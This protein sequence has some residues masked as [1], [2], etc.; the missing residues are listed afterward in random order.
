M[1]YPDEATARQLAAARPDRST[2]LAANAGSGKTKVLTDRV[3]RLLL[4]GTPPQHILCLT[5]TKA[6]ASEMQN[7][8]F[9]RLGEWAML[10]EDD[11]RH[12]VAKLSPHTNL[13]DALIRHA[14][15]LFARAIET[16]GGLKIQTIHSF[17]GGLLRRF[18][19]EAGVSPQYRELDDRTSKEILRDV[20]E[21]ISDGPNQRIIDQVAL[22]LSEDVYALASDI[23]S[24]QEKFDQHRTE[25]EIWAWFELADGFDEATLLREVFLGNEPALFAQIATILSSSSKSTDT[26]FAKECVQWASS[27]I[28]TDLLKRC[29]TK[30]LFGEK[31][32]NPLCS[33]WGHSH[34]GLPTKDMREK[35]ADALE[36]L[37]LLMSRVEKYAPILSRLEDAKRTAI[38]HRFARVL[39]PKYLAKKSFA[40]LLDF[41]DMIRKARD[42]LSNSMTAQWVLFRL[43]G[44]I[45]HILVDEAQDTSP[46]QWVV[47]RRLAEEFASGQGAR[48]DVKRTI[49][50]VGDKKQSIYSFQGADPSGFDDMRDFFD[51]RLQA[52]DDPLQ[53]LSLE[54][55]FRSSPA[56]LAATDCVFGASNGYGVGGPPRHIAF[57][58]QMPG[59]VDLWPL[60]ETEAEEKR[61]D[62]WEDPLDLTLPTHHN[63]KLAE[64]ISN[65]ISKLL[66]SGSIPAENGAFRAIQPKD[67]LILV[68]RRS[69]LFQ[70][71]LSK[72]K[73]KRLPV[74]G[75]D[76]LTVGNELAVRD[77]CAL[78][79]FLS[80]ED[81][82]LALAEALKSPLFNWSDRQL[83]ALAHKRKAPNLWRE[84][85]SRKDEFPQTVAIIDDLRLKL[86]VLRPYD[87]LERVLIKHGGRRRFLAR[88]GPEA[89]DGID[90]LLGQARTY[91]TTQTPSLTGFLAWFETEDIKIKRVLDDS[92]NLIR[93]MTTH[94]AKGLESPIVILPD[95]LPNSKESQVRGAL[96]DLDENRPV[97]LAGSV[98]ASDITNAARAT[99]L[100]KAEEER[101]RLLYVAMTRAEKWLIIAGAGAAPKNGTSWYELVKSGMAEL[102][103]Q[104]LDHPLSGG[105]RYQVGA[106]GVHPEGSLVPNDASPTL[107]YWA[108]TETSA[109]PKK[110]GYISP[111]ELGGAKALSGED[112]VLDS[113][114]AKRRGRQIHLLLDALPD[115][116]PADQKAALHHIH[117]DAED[118]ILDH[119]AEGLLEEAVRVLEGSYTWAVFGSHSLSEVPFSGTLPSLNGFGVHG[120][121]DR[122]IIESDRVQIVDFKTNSVLPD[123]AE[124]IPD[125]ILRQ[126]GAYAEAVESMYPDRLVETAVLW[127][128]T[129]KL[130]EVP[131]DIVRAALQRTTIS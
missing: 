131:R 59:R 92:S 125:G 47:V 78:L 123:S 11:L 30:F 19:L 95:T 70:P 18:P 115:I 110:R 113:E 102:E 50:V 15:T 25:P 57:F 72:L 80:L 122:L 93:I 94:G 96:I 64:T 21:N 81:D 5:Y 66:E 109:P 76:L 112:A 45:D 65:Q 75:A 41:D 58:D 23:L 1:S 36:P 55:S 35:H 61:D 8:L 84:L 7:R 74:A 29:A 54:H 77:L 98:S 12:E 4:E 120:V 10:N 44:G 79:S 16:P 91:E 67:I 118:A 33:K 114:K 83:Y 119:E 49:F 71:L 13:D 69:G 90:A 103:T 97:H 53:K 87:L 129:A 37:R 128:K 62:D 86:D 40:G 39:I 27:E 9:K 121:I 28:S 127:T 85:R 34:G 20:L 26:D 105:L 24:S 60:I 106:W 89:E 46:D 56:I 38:L 130:M 108:Q 48:P 63:H 101:R 32:K 73:E 117:S 3:T 51:A 2:W 43:D 42:L 111:S 22:H 17:C 124:R 52:V 68:R 31:T 88:L 100:S 107:P 116:D 82:D 6:A 99:L 14:R 104:T 126:L